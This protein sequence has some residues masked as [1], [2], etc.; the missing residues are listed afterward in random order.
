MI[1][2]LQW[3]FFEPLISRRKLQ[4]LFFLL[5]TSPVILLALFSYIRT[6]RF[7]TDSI[8]AERKSVAFL[9]SNIVDG[10]LDGL[11]DLGVSFATRPKLV[12]NIEAGNWTEALNILQ[13]YKDHFPYIARIFLTDTAGMIKAD[14]PSISG[15]IGTSRIEKDWYKGVVRVWKP[16]VSEAYQREAEPKY[17]VVAVAI[18]IKRSGSSGKD[19]L[20]ILVLQLEMN[21]FSDWANKVKVGPGGIVYIVDQHGHLV[22]HPKFDLQNKIIDFSKVSII[23]KLMKGNSGAEVNYNPVEKEERFAAYETVPDYGWGVVVTQP[24]REAF[25]DRNA[26]LMFGLFIYLIMFGLGLLLAQS[27]IYFFASR[28]KTEDELRKAMSVKSHFTSTVSHELRTPL[29]AIKEGIAI[30]LDSSAGAVNEKQKEFLILAKRN[31]DRLSRLI[32]D[33]LDFQKLESGKMTFHMEEH[34][35][36]NVVREVQETMLVVAKNKG[37][38]MTLSLEDNLPV[39]RF[40]RDKILQ[41]VTNFVNNAIKF[42]EKG[43]IKIS[44]SHGDNFVRVSIQDTGPGIQEEDLPKLFQQFIQLKDA[45]ERKSSGTGLGLA[46]SKEIIEEHKGKIWAESKINEGSVFSFALP[47]HERRA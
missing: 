42:T 15:V 1:K 40:D 39:L 33:I 7:T 6:Y 29:A 25:A 43:S 3:S 14:L 36:N 46:I 20:G 34:D 21:L 28:K 26:N 12:D 32:N 16:Y 44:T 31:V 4:P 10:K 18:P 22:F 13:G 23:R 24:V 45:P 27:M 35:I 2:K 38:D 41:V 47:V 8:V 30:V 37:L 17:T 11:V 19:V 9:A 5:F